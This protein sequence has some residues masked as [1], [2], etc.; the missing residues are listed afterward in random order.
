MNK[1]ILL[2]IAAVLLVAGCTTSGVQFPFQQITTTTVGGAG[3]VI[4]DFIADPTDVYSNSNSR[5]YLTVANKG[6]APVPDANSVIFLTGSALKMD[7]TTGTYW[8]GTDTIY[9]HFAK[10]MNPSD[11]VRETPA[12]E[13]TITWTL[14][15]PNVTRG[16]TRNDI[17]IA[18]VY[19]DYKTTVSG[20]IW[21]YQ[22]SES[23]AARAANRALNKATFSS[24]SGPIALIIRASPDP[25]V[26]GESSFTLNIKV[27]NVGSGALYRTGSVT[28]TSPEDVTLTSDELNKVNIAITAPG[29]TIGTGC[30]GE[31][32]LVGGKD[33]TLSCD[34][35]I[36]SPPPTF[37][38]FP[39]TIAAD[40]GYNTERTASVT[41][42]GR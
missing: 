2:A 37:Q 12:D 10:T 4:S 7:D 27:S 25:V 36:T 31:Q 33:L 24:T 15:A 13:K 30:T 22:Q 1:S 9:R 42:S 6:G 39:I 28:Y 11:P 14:V 3:L 16:Q 38:G 23:D 19:Y 21:V 8:H 20:T 34:L 26:I 41:V 18:R 29:M 17:F 40:Y 35:T 32:E 5:I